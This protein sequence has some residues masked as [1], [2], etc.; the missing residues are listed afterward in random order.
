VLGFGGVGPSGP[1]AGAL[2]QDSVE[3]THWSPREIR[4]S[5]FTGALPWDS[6]ELG[7]E[8]FSGSDP[9]AGALPGDSVTIRWSSHS[10]IPW[11][12]SLELSRGIR[13]GWV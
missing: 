11:S 2:N 4:W 1:F 12:W 5:W 10:G 8:S 13:L 3:S 9:F 7:L 6:A